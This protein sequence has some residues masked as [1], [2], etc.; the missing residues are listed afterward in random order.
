M[1]GDQETGKQSRVVPVTAELKVPKGTRDWHGADVI[2]R[3][4]IL[5]VR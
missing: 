4:H 3:D 1:A 2:L 5:Y